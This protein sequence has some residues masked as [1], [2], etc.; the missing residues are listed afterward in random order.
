MVVISKAVLRDFG[1]EHP[2]AIEA[3]NHWH[4]IAKAQ[5]SESFSDLKTPSIQWITLA[6]TVLCSIFEAIVTA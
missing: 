6:T 1:L 4:K 3:L 2:G 5:D